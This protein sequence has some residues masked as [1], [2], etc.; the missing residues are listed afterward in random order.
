[1]HRHHP[2]FIVVIFILL[3]ASVTPLCRFC[4]KA[5][6]ALSVQLQGQQ[7]QVCRTPHATMQQRC[8][9]LFE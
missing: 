4:V 9:A 8:S 3:A 7:L 2:L 1:M 6:P 5:V